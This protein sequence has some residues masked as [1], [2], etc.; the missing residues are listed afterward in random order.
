MNITLDTNC[1]IALEQNEADAPYLQRIMQRA[2]EEQLTLRVVAISASERQP[3]GD[4]SENFRDFKAKI[5]GVGLEDAEILPPPCILDVTYLDHCILGTEET[6]E[7]AKRIH[8][9]LSP[10]IAYD[11]Q[12]YCKRSGL[13]PAAA[14]ADAKWRNR[15]ID[16]LA[17]WTHIHNG[18]GAFVTSDG[19]FHRPDKKA[20]LLRLG[21]GAILRPREAAA[22]FCP[23]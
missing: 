5:A 16:T 12:D 7:Q 2:T 11:Y 17:L 15:V 22:R 10:T 23:G 18:G 6:P 21:A 14:Q 8:E 19:N 13:D 20:A 9:I 1:I 4:Y 3:D